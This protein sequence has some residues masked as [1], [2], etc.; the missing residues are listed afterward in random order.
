MT[1]LLHF[2][3]LQAIL[4]HSIAHLPDHRKPSPNTRSTIQ[5]A[6]LGAFGSFFTPSP[7]FLESQRRLQPTKGRHKAQTLWGVEQIPCDHQVRP[8]RDPIAPSSRE[9][10]FEAIFQGLEQH[11]R[12]D[13]FRGLGDPLVGSRAGTPSFSSKTLHGPHCLTRPLTHGHTL[14]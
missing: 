5:D 11:R 4:H 13:P 9:P 2:D 10:G 7:S 12:C 3:D 14:Y 1:H 6:V 8:R